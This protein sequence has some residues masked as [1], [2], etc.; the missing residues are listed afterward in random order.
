MCIQLT[1]VPDVDFPAPLGV[2]AAAAAGSMPAVQERE[3]KNHAHQGALL[4]TMQSLLTLMAPAAAAV[5]TI[6]KPV[7]I[8]TSPGACLCEDISTAVVKNP[9]REF[10]ALA[11][12]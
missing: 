11:R 5:P 6:P 12:K 4:F 9:G 8:I 10:A 7:A 1:H 3:I 2:A